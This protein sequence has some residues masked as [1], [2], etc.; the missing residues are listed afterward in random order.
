M[1]YLELI[2]KDVPADLSELLV[3]R[4]T[5]AGFDSFAEEGSEFRAYVLQELFDKEA[6]DGII[7]ETGLRYIVRDLPD[8]NWNK[9]WEKNFSPVMIPGGCFIRAPFHESDPTAKFEI[10]IEPKMSFGTAHHETTAMMIGTMLG[11]DFRNKNVLDMGCGTGVLAILAHKMGAAFIVAIDN[12]TWA[13]TNTIENCERNDAES[14]I[15][16]QGDVG[17][18]TGEFEI[19]LANIN[20]NILL[21][22]IATYAR[23]LVSGGE[24]IM[25]GFYETDLPM[26]RQEA[27]K[28]GLTYAEHRTMNNWVAATFIQ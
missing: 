8:Q 2:M 25:S 21:E 23:C 1:E 3:Y 26:I 24:L 18:I 16:K 14:I 20:R 27:E 15:V 9:E 7:S 11:K 13:Y 6:V 4:L 17:D 12:D 10:I 28:N 22:Q 5:E 19:I